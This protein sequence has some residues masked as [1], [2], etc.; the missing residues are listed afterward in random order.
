MFGWHTEDCD[1]NSINFL[2]F[3]KPKFWYT[4][5]EEHFELF[6]QNCKDIWEDQFSNCSEYLRHKNIMVNPYILKRKDPRLK[7]SKMVQKPGEFIITMPKGLH[8]GFNMGFNLAEA[9]NYCALDSLE[10]LIHA[11]SCQCVRY[12]VKINPLSFFDSLA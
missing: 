7:I 3:G 5:P 4:I 8:A 1:L 2:H 12:S 11:K 10:N 9:V 6:V